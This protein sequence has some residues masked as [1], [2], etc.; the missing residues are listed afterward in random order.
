MHLQFCE[1]TFPVYIA[2]GSSRLLLHSLLEILAFYAGYKYFQILKRKRGDNLSGTHRAWVFAG[3]IFGAL[4]G[5]RLLG[6]LENLSLLRQT[7]NLLFYFYQNKTVVGGFL[8]GLF[9]VE[10]IKKIIGE[11]KSSGDL[12]VRP[13]L[14]AL[15]IG[16][17][18]CFSMGIYEE[19]YGTP[20]TL[21]WG[22][23]LGDGLSRHPV[24]IYEIIFLI[25]LWIFIRRIER[26]GELRTGAT[27]KIFMISYLLFRFILDFIKPH[28]N[29]IPDLS[30][31][32]IACL[33]GLIYYRKEIWSPDRM[34]LKYERIDA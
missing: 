2:F 13:I 11:K 1:L 22:M 29:I 28:Y 16:R 10:W 25:L 26:K 14:L 33:G 21:P 32:Q 7:N 9:G 3:A 5:S 15:I 20:T 23:N 24:A 19:T 12:F 6:G 31:I 17:I 8:G 4:I 30:V 18:G 34:F 27:F